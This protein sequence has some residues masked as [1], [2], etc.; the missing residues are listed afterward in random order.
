MAIIKFKR[1]LKVNLP[2]L[3]LGEPAFTTDTRKVYVGN[4][5]NNTE[6][7]S[8]LTASAT[9]D[10][11]AINN[12]SMAQ[13]DIVFNG[14]NLGDTVLVNCSI[15]LQGLSLTGYVSATNNVKVTLYNLTGS[16]VDLGS[17][18]FTATILR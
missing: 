14:A 17:A 11:S 4:G 2:T 9:I 6:L 1:G 8:M 5:T 10:F 3:G 15:D 7:T 18:I 12:D 13:S 16:S